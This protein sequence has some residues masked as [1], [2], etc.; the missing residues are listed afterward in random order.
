MTKACAGPLAAAA[1]LLASLPGGLRC[2][3]A[4]GAARRCITPPL[5]KG[6]V[7][8]A[9]FNPGRAATGVHDDL[10]ARC[11]ALSDGSRKLVLCSLDS[12]GLFAEDVEHIRSLVRA[13]V[14]AQLIIAATHVHQAPDT[15]GLWGPQ[16]GVS[17]RNPAYD[18][19]VAERTA[20]AA[21]EAAGSLRPATL[22]L[23]RA[24]SPELESFINDTRPPVVTDAELLLMHLAGRDGR[25]IATALNWA[26]HPEVLG[27]NNTLVTADYAAWL[28]RR[29]E[30][31]LGGVALLFNGALGGMQSPLGAKVTDPATGS[32]APEAS[33]RKAELIGTRVAD[34][35]ADALRT[36][37][38]V[39]VSAVH[40]AEKRVR[41]PVTNARMVQAA[42]AGVF[43]AARRIGADGSLETLVGLLRIEK[44]RRA[45]LE[46]ALVPGELYPEL[47]RGGIERLPG[48]DFPDAPLE[49][50][51]KQMMRAP[52]RWLIGLA[53]DEIGY[54]IPK[55]EWDESPPWLNNAARRWYGEVNSLGPEAAARIA[56]AL[57][58]LLVAATNRGK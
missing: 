50:P 16:L 38:P 51:L 5:D 30:Q 22:R 24:S 13:R 43:G 7:W 27:S 19:L 41:I 28:Y 37:R 53:N 34:L 56:A 17:G 45:V 48:A 47:S 4:A 58:E 29:L 40:Y 25:T 52:W 49:I 55:A 20:E 12:I 23:A 14:S 3:L 35:A 1:L 15:L 21:I 26:N 31:R 11:L 39:S 57:S 36:A 44:G 2:E 42:Q 8:L 46:A 54:I 6:P 33:F 18:R 10:W 9:G 32:P